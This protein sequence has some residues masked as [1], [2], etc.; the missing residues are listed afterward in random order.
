MFRGT[1]REVVIQESIF[2]RKGVDRI[3]RFAFELARTRQR[4]RLTL[5]TKSN[6]IIHTMTFLDERFAAMARDYPDVNTTKYHIDILTAHFVQHPDW[7]DVVYSNLL[8]HP[9]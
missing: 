7:F 2:T 8:R 6:G 3:L 9:L 5:A 1:D 4:K